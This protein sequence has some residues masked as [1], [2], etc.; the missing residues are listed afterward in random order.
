MQEFSAVAPKKQRVSKPIPS[1]VIGATK[2]QRDEWLRQLAST[3]VPLSELAR[4]P[5]HGLKGSAFFDEMFSRRILV[6]RAVWYMKLLALQPDVLP[7]AAAIGAGSRISGASTTAGLSTQSQRSKVWT[8]ETRKYLDSTLAEMA[9]CWRFSSG[10]SSASAGAGAGANAGGKWNAMMGEER[11]KESIRAWS[12]F[13]VQHHFETEGLEAKLACAGLELQSSTL[14][15]PQSSGGSPAN[16]S[17]SSVDSRWH[18]SSARWSYTCAFLEYALHDGVLGRVSV[19]N[20][21]VE[22]LAGASGITSFGANTTP[23]TSSSTGSTQTPG[24]L[25]RLLTLTSL[26]CHF[27]PW[28]TQSRMHAWKLCGIYR[29]MWERCA[30][31]VNQAQ[32]QQQHSASALPTMHSLALTALSNAAPLLMDLCGG[33]IRCIATALPNTQGWFAASAGAAGAGVGWTEEWLRIHSLHDPMDDSSTV[34]EPM[35]CESAAWVSAESLAGFAQEKQQES[36]MATKSFKPEEKEEGEVDDDVE[37][38]DDSLVIKRDQMHTAARKPNPA[39]AP[40]V[41]ISLRQSSPPPSTSSALLAFSGCVSSTSCVH[42]WQVFFPRWLDFCSDVCLGTVAQMEGGGSLVPS[43]AVQCRLVSTIRPES[44][45]IT[46]ATGLAPSSSSTPNPQHPISLFSPAAFLAS[47]S[48]SS[49]TPFIRYLLQ[50]RAFP[51]GVFEREA[52]PVWILWAIKGSRGSNAAVN[53]LAMMLV[54]YFPQEKQ[55]GGGGAGDKI[56]LLSEKLFEFLLAFRPRCQ[57]ELLRMTQLY[58]VLTRMHLF[59]YQR[60]L[61]HLLT[62]G[63]LASSSS[64]S[65]DASPSSSSPD[66]P[67]WSFLSRHYL[68]HLPVPVDHACVPPPGCTLPSQVEA[69]VSGALA[70]SSRTGEWEKQRRLLLGRKEA[71]ERRIE[72]LVW[73]DLVWLNELDEIASEPAQG[74]SSDGGLLHASRTALHSSLKRGSHWTPAD[75]RL[76]AEVWS[77]RCSNSS[78]GAT[79]TFPSETLQQM[80]SDATTSSITSHQP[81]SRDRPST[82]LPPPTCSSLALLAGLPMNAAQAVLDHCVRVIGEYV[83]GKHQLVHQDRLDALTHP[84]FLRLLHTVIEWLEACEFA[85]SIQLLQ[86]SLF[87][88][89]LSLL[90]SSPPGSL[91]VLE[92]ILFGCIRRN[93]LTA[94][95]LGMEGGIRTQ[96]AEVL[97]MQPSAQLAEAFLD[98]QSLPVPLVKWLRTNV[99]E[100]W[101]PAPSNS[102]SPA[103]VATAQILLTPSQ[104]QTL[105]EK[106]WEMHFRSHLQVTSFHRTPPSSLPLSYI[107]SLIP[108]THA[109]IGSFVREVLR[110]MMQAVIKVGQVTSA[111]LST[112]S[113]SRRSLDHRRAHWLFAQWSILTHAI[114]L[115]S[116]RA[117]TSSGTLAQRISVSDTFL[118]QLCKNFTRL[119]HDISAAPPAAAS[120]AGAGSLTGLSAILNELDLPTEVPAS[121]A[122]MAHLSSNG[123]ATSASSPTSSPS[124]L[125]LSFLCLFLTHTLSCDLGYAWRPSKLAAKLCAQISPVTSVEMQGWW[126]NLAAAVLGVRGHHGA[127]RSVE[128]WLDSTRRLALQK[129]V[130]TEQ[131]ADLMPLVRLRSQLANRG[132]PTAILPLSALLTSPAFQSMFLTSPRVFLQDVLPLLSVAGVKEVVCTMVQRSSTE[133]FG[134]FVQEHILAGR[135][136]STNCI[137]S[138]MAQAAPW[139]ARTVSLVFQLLFPTSSSTTPEHIDPSTFL[140]DVLFPCLAIGSTVEL[141]IAPHSYG[142]RVEALRR[143]YPCFASEVT[144]KLWDDLLTRF[145]GQ[146]TSWLA[147]VRRNSAGTG[148]MMQQQHGALNDRRTLEASSVSRSSCSCCDSSFLLTTLLH[149]ATERDGI[150]PA[151]PSPFT[152]HL[153]D[154][155]VLIA[156]TAVQSQRQQHQWPTRLAIEFQH[157]LTLRLACLEGSFSLIYAT[158]PEEYEKLLQA[159]LMALLHE[160]G[161]VDDA[162]LCLPH[163]HTSRG[164]IG[165]RFFPTMLAYFQTM[166]DA[167]SA[168]SRGDGEAASARAAAAAGSAPSKSAGGDSLLASLH[169]LF[170]TVCRSSLSSSSSRPSDAARRELI[171]ACLPFGH[172]WAEE[173]PQ[174]RTP[175]HSDVSMGVGFPPSHGAASSSSA[176]AVAL[177]DPWLLLEGLASSP[178]IDA[179]YEQAKAALPPAGLPNANH[180][181][182]GSTD[183]MQRRLQGGR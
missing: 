49:P 114:T 51:G 12:D 175:A 109:G 152:M 122:A 142:T 75:R 41:P 82:S 157:S 151:E 47:I 70:L 149:S 131:L 108:C 23:S 62:T 34:T 182:S 45:R 17:V 172:G 84:R 112:I 105:K 180:V 169:A 48:P 159:I 40:H 119:M 61:Q 80:H 22:G 117:A 154:Q 2:E 7:A 85:L 53:L 67:S 83:N 126:A 173:E 14:A 100:K 11:A 60:F 27:L 102:S 39:H 18:R 54:T 107:I 24:Q 52:L 174:W 42:S 130:S 162:E 90:S 19:L 153:V 5:P 4:S 177:A 116:R 181:T 43:V 158:H 165:A 94:V 167:V 97:R 73:L 115:L 71:D 33:M 96:M 111:E 123:S 66:L 92:S 13:G 141:A 21:L 163:G 124:S 46:Y 139:N 110:A 135:S 63:V 16:A 161:D 155:C 170:H 59:P 64:S 125:A 138:T 178:F 103:S 132:D 150:T 55:R 32:Q 20:W 143:V 160:H 58:G 26:A 113:S 50:L 31:A 156:L 147:E 127:G 134:A 57:L 148:E 183:S 29:G 128:S 78:Q 15:A 69:A 1:L 38:R 44:L 35:E 65:I 68:L 145:E 171:S 77:A 133:D 136:Q 164:G 6:T 106:T 99:L 3:E 146:L 129:I 168:N 9:S 120:S 166:I 36:T 81:L 144:S 93:H 74:D 137:R 30:N 86:T 87:E 140:S 91:A 88:L 28:L 121:F 101:T 179:M 25:V 95:C 37:M 8:E 104:Q 89:Y 72:D 76:H 118:N 176:A 79:A 56:S 10:S 98:A